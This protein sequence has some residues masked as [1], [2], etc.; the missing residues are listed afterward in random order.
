[1]E[2]DTPLIHSIIFGILLSMMIPSIVCYLFIFSQ[3]LQYRE[4]L[5]RINNHIILALLIIN[6]IEVTTEL[7]FTLTVLHTGYVAV[8]SPLFCQFWIVYNYSI[9]VIGLMYMAYG[10]IQRYFLIFHRVFFQ[11][12]LIFFHYTPLVIFLIYPTLLY[13]GL[14]VIY[15][16][17]AAFDYT[18]FVCGGACYEYQFT[19]GLFDWLSNVFGPVIIGVIATTLLIVRVLIQKRR[20]HQ[21]E[22][23]RRNRK[24]VVQLA[25][26]SIMYVIIWIPNVICFIVPL[27]VSSPLSSQIETGFLNYLQ[28][29][30]CL[31]CPFMCL[32]GLPEIRDSFK[33]KFIRLRS[34]QP[35]IQDP[36]K[37]VAA[38]QIRQ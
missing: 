30:I 34:V 15:P 20:V 35:Q 11:Q 27:I 38:P 18:Q 8:Q 22:I 3:F 16:C 2:F 37:T 13:F 28:Y 9:I 17:E 29:M 26:I 32:I 25:S 23:W 1:M 4:L 19:L 24:M 14:V 10:C 6:F 7:P 36:T 21:R 12:H 5:K 33:K 31:L